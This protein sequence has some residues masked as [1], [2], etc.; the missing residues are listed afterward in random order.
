MGW[1]LTPDV[2]KLDL[3]TIFRSK[4]YPPDGEARMSPASL[5]ITTQQGERRC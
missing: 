4:V 2:Q 3:L 1:Y 5:A